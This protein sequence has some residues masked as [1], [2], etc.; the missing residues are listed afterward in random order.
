[1]SEKLRE[2]SPE[3][4]KN[5][6][7]DLSDPEVRKDLNRELFNTLNERQAFIAS[8]FPD[9]VTAP[10]NVP[11]SIQDEYGGLRSLKE[12]LEWGVTSPNISQLGQDEYGAAIDRFIYPHLRLEVIQKRVS[13]SAAE[14]ESLL[15][16]D[17]ERAFKVP[18]IDVSALK[19]EFRNANGD[20]E[21]LK[22]CAHLDSLKRHAD[23]DTLFELLELRAEINANLTPVELDPKAVKRWERKF[24]REARAELRRKKWGI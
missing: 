17:K 24:E 5:V 21:L 22:V 7:L 2:R 23:F 18:D 10:E 11:E 20:E 13:D 4:L 9:V 14:N 12:C 15:D 6:E 1:M 8:E 16:A 19:S 3:E